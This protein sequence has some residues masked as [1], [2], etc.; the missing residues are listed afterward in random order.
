[1]DIITFSNRAIDVPFKRHGRDFNGWDCWGLIKLAYDQVFGIKVS[2]GDFGSPEEN[3]EAFNQGK[4]EWFKVAQERPGDVV[5]M[6]N[7]R[8]ACHV[9]LVIEKGLM[10]HTQEK[11]GTV[12]ERF[13]SPTLKQRVVGIYRHAEFSSSS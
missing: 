1:M 3:A 12:V 7:G 6:R 11:Y 10:L 9:G 2:D 4:E 8:L 13:Y 5:L